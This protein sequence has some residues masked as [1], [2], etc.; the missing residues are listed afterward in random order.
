MDDAT[1]SVGFGD[2][3][4]AKGRSLRMLVVDVMLGDVVLVA[5]PVMVAGRRMIRENIMHASGLT[6][7]ERA[8]PRI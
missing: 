2:I 7:I 4:S 6:L 5:W 1:H 3:V 8:G